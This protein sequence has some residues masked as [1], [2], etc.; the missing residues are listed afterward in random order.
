VITV[1]FVRLLDFLRHLT[2]FTST[3][4]FRHTVRKAWL[5]YV[6]LTPLVLK[7]IALV[8]LTIF[9]WTRSFKLLLF[10]WTCMCLSLSKPQLLNALIRLEL[11]VLSRF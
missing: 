7:Q 6:L 4:L 5:P 3:I 9:A 11:K 1:L 2:T 10:C 8:I